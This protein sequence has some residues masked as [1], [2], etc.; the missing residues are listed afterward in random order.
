[1]LTLGI[2]FIAAGWCLKGNGLNDE[3]G[4]RA[5]FAGFV[6]IGLDVACAGVFLLAIE[7]SRYMPT[8]FPHLWKLFS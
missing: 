1:M 8:D 5:V 4:R 6:L 3:I 7:A 2:A